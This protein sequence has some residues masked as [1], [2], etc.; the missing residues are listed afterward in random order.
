MKMQDAYVHEIPNPNSKNTA[1]RTNHFPT[2]SVPTSQT[3]LS[4]LP[5]MNTRAQT[6]HKPHQKQQSQ[7]TTN[8]L[9]KYGSRALS[10][11]STVHA[12]RTGQ[13]GYDIDERE[14]LGPPGRKTCRKGVQEGLWFHARKPLAAV[15]TFSLSHMPC[16]ARRWCARSLEVRRKREADVQRGR[17][18]R[19]RINAGTVN[20]GICLCDR[21]CDT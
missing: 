18:S 15:W 6:S 21:T 10:G 13:I 1:H 9:T 3:P 4:L 5:I 2:L 17:G 20:I 11:V 12:R 8:E 14:A 19:L 16:A 7:P